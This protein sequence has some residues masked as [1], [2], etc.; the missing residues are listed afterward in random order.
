M[1]RCRG[2]HTVRH[3][4]CVPPRRRLGELVARERSKIQPHTLPYARACHQTSHKPKTKPRFQFS[5]VGDDLTTHHPRPACV[6]L[7]PNAFKRGL[8][9]G[10]SLG[11]D[12][13]KSPS[14]VC[15]EA[16]STGMN[17]TRTRDATFGEARARSETTTKVFVHVLVACLPPFQ[18]SHALTTRSRGEFPARS[19]AATR[20]TP[21]A[22]GE[23][24]RRRRRR[25]RR[26]RRRDA[27]AA[28]VKFAP[29]TRV[30][31][32]I[33]RTQHARA[34]L[35]RPRRRRRAR[36]RGTPS[37]VPSRARDRSIAHPSKARA[38]LSTTPRA[39]FRRSI[40]RE[41][42]DR[43]PSPIAGPA[44]PPRRAIVRHARG[45][46]VHARVRTPYRVPRGFD[47]KTHGA[48]FSCDG[49]RPGH[50]RSRWVS[51][52]MLERGK[53]IHTPC[54]RLID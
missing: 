23:D 49:Y 20:S 42:I 15:R 24:A 4:G 35:P 18:R 22:V 25:R 8:V 45:I 37:R 46:V 28:G 29:H 41:S 53:S 6:I 54:V 16:Y 5:H 47:K 12:W 50:D 31:G 51:P 30:K 14:E 19:R 13:S 33:L 27:T 17:P 44:A 39:R 38:R 3:D 9:F 52:H 21:R 36:A 40:D 11:C 1:G 2:V 32:I 26:E 43:A 10:C 34:R 7:V 48:P